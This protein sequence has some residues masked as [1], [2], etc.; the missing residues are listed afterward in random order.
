MPQRAGWSAVRAATSAPWFVATLLPLSAAPLILSG[1]APTFNCRDFV[2]CIVG[3]LKIREPAIINACANG[4]AV[5]RGFSARLQ[6]VVF[7]SCPAAACATAGFDAEQRHDSPYDLTAS[8]DVL[9]VCCE[10]RPPAI[11][12]EIER[13]V[14]SSPPSLSARSLDV[15]AVKL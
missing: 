5:I 14:S 4:S 2:A 10:S 11:L 3:L 1:Q 13:P 12:S 8:Q 7:G 6:I 15:A 9:S